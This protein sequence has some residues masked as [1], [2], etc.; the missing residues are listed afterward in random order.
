MW[1]VNNMTCRYSNRCGFIREIARKMPFTAD[2]YQ[3]KYCALKI[4]RC[5]IY[6]MASKIGMGRVPCDVMPN[7]ELALFEMVL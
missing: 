3:E 2:R 5:A 1:M 4:Y 6:K 7:E